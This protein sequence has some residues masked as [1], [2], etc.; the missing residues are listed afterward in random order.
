MIGNNPPS[1][2]EGRFAPF[3]YGWR[4]GQLTQ[5]QADKVVSPDQNNF[6]G[7][8]ERTG[9]LDS[10]YHLALGLILILVLSKAQS[11]PPFL[12][13]SQNMTP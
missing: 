3:H 1:F 4:C 13:S 7:R 9:I 12:A 6:L 8:D 11:D 10:P 5:C 2:V